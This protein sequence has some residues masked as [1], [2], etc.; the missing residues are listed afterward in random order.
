M[1]TEIVR[2]PVTVRRQQARPVGGV[3][4]GERVDVG[5]HRH[6]AVA[7]FGLG[8]RGAQAIS[9]CGHERCVER[10]GDLQRHHLLGAE[11]LGVSGRR[12][13]AVGRSGDDH[14]AGGVVVRDPHVG[15]GAP[16]R[17]VDLVVV[18]AEHGGHGAG[19]RESGV[20]HR[21]AAFAHEADAVVETEDT[22]GRERG[23]LAEAVAGA[24]ARCDAEALDRVEHHQ[25]RHVRGQLGVAG[26]LEFAGVGVAEQGTDVAAGDVAG[27]VD[28][29]PALV[30][31]PG[32]PHAGALGPLARE[33]ESEHWT[34]ARPHAGERG[35]TDG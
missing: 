24:V 13:D 20:V 21:R 26:V 3:L 25:A 19:L 18:E 9:R 8:E 33:G 17:D 11:V 34:Q 16:A 23:V 7:R 5:D 30:V 31:A 27:L 1:A 6:V 2:R 4:V 22:G 35:A 12:L 15:V 32:Q 10:A 14:L 29:F 28:Q